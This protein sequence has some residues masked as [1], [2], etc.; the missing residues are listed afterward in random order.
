MAS[1]SDKNSTPVPRVHDGWIVGRLVAHGRANY[2]WDPQASMSYYVRLET[3]ETEA[4]AQQR[5][6][7][8]DQNARPI[9]GREPRR[10]P[11]GQAGGTR[12]LWGADL[13]RAIR[14][15]RSGVDIGKIVA[16][17]IVT[18]ERL[19]SDATSNPPKRG[20]TG[21]W[22]KWE[23]ETVQF[24]AQRNR[25]ARAVN[26]NYR[27]AR[28]DGVVGREALALYMIHEGARRLAEARYPN[29]E[30]RKAFIDGV[31]NFFEVSPERKALIA[32]AVQ[33]LNALKAAQS[34]SA[35][36]SRTSESPD[37][38]PTPE[39]LTRE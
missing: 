12:E 13:G 23:V 37:H 24:V 25:F 35:T 2:K 27:N 4:G 32:R 21:Y 17:K 7:H 31:K 19:I 1:G 28:Q 11:Q 22:N 8:A 30:D 34:S 18:R 3:S 39:P 38:D 16:A 9:D 29:P 5:R 33:R 20:G 36:K 14:E 6:E 10:A 26:E 15:S